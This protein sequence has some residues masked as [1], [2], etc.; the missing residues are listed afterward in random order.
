[1][2]THKDKKV[3]KEHAQYLKKRRNNKIYINVMR[4]G[5]LLA[6]IILWEVAAQ[7][8]WIDTFIM[9]SPSRVA[10]SLSN[11]HST[12]ELW[13]HIGVTVLETVVGFLIGTGLGVLMAIL[14]W[15][16]V[17]SRKIA[18]PYLVV[19]N[20]LPK[21]ALGP[22]IIV[23]IGAGASAIITMA[24]LISVIVTIM[25]VLHGFLS[26]SSEKTILMRSFGANKLQIL[27]KVILPASVP[28]IMS[29]LKI[30]VGMVM[31][32]VITGEFLVAKEG[33]G[34]LIVYGGQVFQL[35]LVMA[36][37]IVLAAVAA[38]MYLGVSK[39]ESMYVKWR[40]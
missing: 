16:S 26:I 17:N 4:I 27:Q 32:G 25:N 24:L 30:N 29:T 6:L 31:V 40:K 1:M 7:L 37:V 8:G 33:I 38:I 5:L 35:D 28:T 21:V 23:W 12:G 18:E 10:R 39:I 9:S 2:S 13:M 20:S 15:W 19:L 34:Y 11:L 14:L 36:G 22:I 3:S